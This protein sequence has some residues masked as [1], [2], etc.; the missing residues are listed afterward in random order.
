MEDTRIAIIGCGNMGR[1]LIGGLIANGLASQFLSGADPDPGKRGQIAKQYGIA[2]F[3]DNREAV[4]RVDVVVLA[5]KPQIMQ[6]TAVSLRNAVLGR[7][8]LIISVAAGI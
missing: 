8:C 4:S 2:V 3:A 6:A 7:G 1:S 5:V